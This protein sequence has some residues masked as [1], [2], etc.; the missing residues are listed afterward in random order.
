M[1]VRPPTAWRVFSRHRV[2]L[3][4]LGLLVALLGVVVFGSVLQPFDPERVGAGPSLVPPDATHLMGTDELGRDVLSRV[5]SGTRVSMLVGLSAALI[6]TLLGIVLGAFAGFFGGW[7]DDLLMRI[8]E[9]FQIIPRFFL[10]MMLVAF[11]GASILNLILAI[12]LLSW[13]QLARIVRAEFLTLKSRHYVDA[14]RVVGAST[15]ALIFAEI[16]PN[17]LGPVIVSATLLV[18]QA[19]IIEAG[20]SYIGLGDPNQVSLGLML[21]Q[22]QQIMRTAWWS[23]AFPGL[24]IFLTVLGINLAGDGLNDVFNPRS[25]DR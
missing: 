23:T 9:V 8:T 1:A 18:G 20:L 3:V 5:V 17:A 21:Q 7:I 25:R 2:S 22:A 13:P 15:P 19:I 24:V 4:G 10:A 12:A 6:S 16:L 11:F 14:A